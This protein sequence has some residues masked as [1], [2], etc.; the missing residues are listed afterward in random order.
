M[1][2]DVAQLGK[3]MV[4]AASGVVG[5]RWPE[6][7]DYFKDELEDFARVLARIAVRYAAGRLTE[8]NA[9]ALVRAQV[10]SMEIVLLAVEGMGIIMVEMAIN[11]AI[12]VVRTTVN[13]A[14][15]F[16]LM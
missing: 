14:L 16:A 13:E 4:G 12:D 10:K 15:G 9:R 5:Q 6:I 2:M 7:E 11:A 1:A 8:D 3:D